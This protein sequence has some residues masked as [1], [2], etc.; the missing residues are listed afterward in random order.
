MSHLSST[1]PPSPFFF[2]VTVSYW[3]GACSVGLACWSV[4]SRDPPVSVSQHWDS[5]ACHQV[6]LLFSIWGL[7]LEL[8]SPWYKVTTSEKHQQP[9]SECLKQSLLPFLKKISN[10][11]NFNSC[12]LVSDALEKELQTVVSCHRLLGIEPRSSARTASNHLSSPLMAYFIQ[13]LLCL[14]FSPFKSDFCYFH[15]SHF[16]YSFPLFSSPVLLN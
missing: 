11:F 6:K 3:P 4:C 9:S 13:L 12:A 7:G 10:L 14:D 15:A 5:K 1:P 16:P 2:E 8:R